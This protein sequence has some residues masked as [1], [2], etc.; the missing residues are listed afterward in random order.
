MLLSKISFSAL[1]VLLIAGC[2]TIS[3]SD[4]AHKEILLIEH[5]E[6]WTEFQADGIVTINYKNFELRKSINIK[7]ISDFY[8]ITVYDSGVFGMKP[9]P[10][11]TV[12]IDSLIQIKTQADEKPIT[13]KITE[14][15]G[16]EYLLN[17][18][19]LIKYSS[20]IILKGQLLLSNTVHIAFSEKMQIAR[21]DNLTSPQSLIFEYQDQ[22]RSIQFLQN[23]EQLAKIEIDKITYFLD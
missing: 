23:N 1:I 12:K 8:K 13:H 6:N 21:I 7:K 11:I 9:E 16:I 19:E 18:T 4:F 14:F 17:P 5:L 10:F 3:K 22:L 2:A 20:E 15:P